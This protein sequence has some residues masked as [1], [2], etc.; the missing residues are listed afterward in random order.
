M[1]CCSARDL[2]Q[3]LRRVKPRAALCL[4]CNV[5]EVIYCV[6]FQTISPGHPADRLCPYK[7]PVLHSV[8]LQT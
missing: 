8:S 4:K 3:K 2:L 7:A 5:G 6:L 1:V